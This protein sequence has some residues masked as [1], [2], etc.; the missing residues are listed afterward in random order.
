MTFVTRDWLLVGVVVSLCLI[1]V[2][3]QNELQVGYAVVTPGGGAAPV[4]TALFSFSDPSGTLLWEAGVAAVEPIASGRIFVERSATTRTAIALANASNQPASGTLVL[5]NSAGAEVART[6]LALGPHQHRARFIDELFE[7]L[8]PGLTSGSLT[9]TSDQKVAALTL[10]ENKNERDEALYAT[11]PVIDLAAAVS[12]ASI[13]FPQIAVGAGYSTQIILVN[14]SSQPVAGRIRL[15]RSDGSPLLLGGVSELSYAIAGDGTYRT[16]LSSPSDVQVGYAV[17]TLETGSTIPSGSAIF[18]IKRNERVVSEAGVAAQPATTRARIFVDRARTETGVALASRGN[19]ATSVTFEL[20][21]RHGVSLATTTQPLPA[22][23]HV[24][25]FVF[26]LFAGLPEGFTGLLEISSPVPIIPITLKLTTNSRGDTILTT[27]PVGDL[28]R[29]A[30]TALQVFPQIAVGAGFATRLLLINPDRTLSLVGVLDLFQSSGAALTLPLAGQTASQFAYNISAGSAR[31]FRPGNSATP[32]QIILDLF[33]P[34]QGEIAVNAGSALQLAPTVIDSSGDARDDLAFS[35]SSLSTE[36]ATISAGGR[37]EGRAPGFSTLTVSSGAAVATVTLT[38]ARITSGA[39]GAFEIAGIAQDR[40]RRVYLTSSR[41]HTILLAQDITKTPERYAGV[42]QTLGLRNDARLS[43]RFSSPAFLNYDQVEGS[44]YVSDRGN[45]VIRRV[46][47]G[48]TGQVE[49]L[50]GST[51]LN[52]PEG[53]ALDNRGYLWVADSGSHTLKRIHLV[54]GAV[55]TIA[56]QSGSSGLVDGTASQARFNAPA[57]IALEIEPL[58]R[59]LERERTGAP[60]P[61]V[62]IIVADSGNGRLRRV[63]ENGQVETLDGSAASAGQLVSRSRSSVAGGPRLGP[64]AV[65]LS[66]SSPTGVAIDPLGNIYV[67]EPNS[68]EVKT[69][70]QTGQVVAAA[71]SGTFKGPRGIAVAQSGRVLV[72]ETDRSGQEISYGEPVISSITPDRINNQ[73][74][75]V[76]T[77]V[78]KNF[79]PD[80]LVIAAGVQIPG[81]SLN[82]K[83]TQTISFSVP[84]LPSGRNTVTVHNRGGLAQTSLLVEPAQLAGLSLGRITTVAGGTTFAGEGTAA[85]SG[86]LALPTSASLDAAG[87]LFIADTANNRVRKVNPITGIMTTVAG[88]GAFGFEG[89]QGPAAAAAL[90][91]P[92]GVVADAAGNVFI[93]DWANSRIRRVDAKTGVVATVAGNG[94][95]GFSGDNGA[96]LSASLNLPEGIALDAA[97]NLLIADTAN[98]RIRRVDGATGIITTVA[99]N[100]QSAYAGDGGPATSAALGRPAGVAVD[101]AGNILIADSA[102]SRIRKV[103]AAT[104]VITSVAGN[105]QKSYSGDNGLATVASIDSP[106]DVAVDAAGNMFIAD[107]GNHR[108]RRVDAGSGII[109]TLAGY[110]QALFA[111]DSGPATGAALAAPYG[112]AIDASGNVI[113]VDTANNR[114]RKIDGSTRVITTVAGNGQAGFLGDNGPAWAAALINPSGIGLDSTGNLFVADTV[115]HRIRRKDVGT[116]VMTTVAGSNQSGLGGDNGPATAAG[117]VFPRAVTVDSARNLFVAD[118]GSHRIRKVSAAGGIIS[119]VAGNGQRGFSGDIGL[120]TQAALSSP[121]AVA[122][123]GAGNLFIADR[124]NHRIRKVAVA[125]GIITT[126]AGNGNNAYSG[127]NGPATAA[128]IAQPQGVAVDS[129]GNLFIADTGNNRI[130]KVNLANGTI[131]TVAGNGQLDFYGAGGPAT[132]AALAQPFMVAVDSAGNLFISAANR[133]H[134]VD[135]ATGILTTVVGNGEFGFSGDNGPATSASLGAAFGVALDAAGNLYISEQFSNRVRAVRGPVR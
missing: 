108:T 15:V 120:A 16:E 13:V 31:Q 62:S 32:Q 112:V 61:P 78:G 75:A 52:R 30:S 111:G 94:T 46:R 17:V 39:A 38:V 43:S 105:G 85:V 45:N 36:V 135:A 51:S 77:I 82:I 103:D 101:R 126:V 81:A 65:A 11:L 128:S 24:A 2:Y 40:A 54:T 19:P 114:I 67:T 57:G 47:P 50:A 53:I 55:E 28:T 22:G 96:A 88:S 64:R 44:L 118:T 56:G 5:R 107:T 87:N 104:R 89:D 134:R 6:P 73:G 117:L 68:N 10:R 23:G 66:F 97:G 119:T 60:P 116:G 58:A 99:G 35:Y 86:S 129:A 122:V 18:Q 63:R 1:F 34:A 98:F 131:T 90:A 121:W 106:Q 12:S 42:H 76:V 113:V 3:A 70:L 8:P 123:D 79:A 14:R 69:V 29:P 25:R 41:D 93:A 124:D 132:A 91:F 102:S 21:D 115:N 80:T 72:A 95:S 100:G 20:L 84:A 27:L 83:D 71:Q 4:G 109:T 7:G 130:R 9:F 92:Q 26:E 33:G 37:V 48:P 59:Q 133:V 110:G 125:T 74:G 49:T 127:D